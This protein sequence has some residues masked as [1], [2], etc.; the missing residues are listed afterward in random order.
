ME[1]TLFSGWIY[2]TLK[3]LGGKLEMGN[4]SMRKAIGLRRRKTTS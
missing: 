1:A 2:D 3:P 4:P